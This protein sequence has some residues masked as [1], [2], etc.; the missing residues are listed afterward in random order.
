MTR[1]LVLFLLSFP[2]EVTIMMTIIKEE[3]EEKSN[4]VNSKSSEAKLLGS[5]PSAANY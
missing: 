3:A 4:V 2:H 5:N 1:E